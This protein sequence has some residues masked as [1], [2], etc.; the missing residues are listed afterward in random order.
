VTPAQLRAQKGEWRGALSG[1]HRAGL[2]SPDL[3]EIEK[4]ATCTVDVPDPDNV[5]EFRLTI[6][7][8]EG[9]YRGGRFVFN[10]NIPKTFPQNAPRLHCVPRIYHPNIDLDG[11]VCLNILREDWKP[12]LN[13]N[14]VIVGVQFLFLEPNAADPLNKTAAADLRA[15]RESFRRNVQRS[16]MGSVVGDQAFDNVLL[17]Q[18]SSEGRA[19]R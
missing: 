15:S 18:K 16:M 7:P 12:V 4:S 1:W 9:V 17:D 11:N 8:D 19:A 10:V 6:T 13:L 3:E 5:L 2:T 14:A